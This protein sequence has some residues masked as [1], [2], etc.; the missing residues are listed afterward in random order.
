MYTNLMWLVSFKEEILDQDEHGRRQPCEAGGRGWSCDATSEGMLKAG[1]GR[2]D[3]PLKGPEGNV[4]LQHHTLSGPSDT[5][6][7]G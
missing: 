4:A 3:H 1:R 2:Q 7:W 6:N 5:H